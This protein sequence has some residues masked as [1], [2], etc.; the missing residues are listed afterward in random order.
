MIREIITG[1]FNSLFAWLNAN[2]AKGKLAID[3]QEK[4]DDL[5]RA[6]SRVAKWERMQQDSASKRSKPD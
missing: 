6:G 5:L 3:S 1:F 4:P 2:A